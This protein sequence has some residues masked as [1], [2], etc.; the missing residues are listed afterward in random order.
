[1]PN[2]EHWS[3]TSPLARRVPRAVPC[4]STLSDPNG[5][6]RRIGRNGRWANT[7]AARTAQRAQASIPQASGQHA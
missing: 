2:M 3:A 6:G 4:R 7:G 1:M 5:T